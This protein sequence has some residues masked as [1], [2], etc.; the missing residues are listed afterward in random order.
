MVEYPFNPSISSQ[1]AVNKYGHMFLDFFGGTKGR[2]S[3]IC[4][5]LTHTHTHTHIF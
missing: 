3:P 2:P 4:T 1:H 5:V